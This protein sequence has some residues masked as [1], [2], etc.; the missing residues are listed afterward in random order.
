M[1]VSSLAVQIDEPLYRKNRN[2]VRRPRFSVCFFS[3]PGEALKKDVRRWARVKSYAARLTG[4]KDKGGGDFGSASAW[5]ETRKRKPGFNIRWSEMVHFKVR[6]HDPN[7]IPIDLSGAIIHVAVLDGDS[8][9]IVGIFP[10]NLAHLLTYSRKGSALK[11][12]TRNSVVEPSKPV[13]RLSVMSNFVGNGLRRG[14]ETNEYDRP[15][16]IR[17]SSS[18]ISF[19]S[20][21]LSGG[22]NRSKDSFGSDLSPGKI[23]NSASSGRFGFDDSK[24]LD[25]SV[26]TDIDEHLITSGPSAQMAGTLDSR[27]WHRLSRTLRRSSSL[28]QMSQKFSQSSL[29]AMEVFS[30]NINHSLRKYGIKVGQIQFTVDSFWLSDEAAERRARREN[31]EELSTGYD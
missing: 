1:F 14:K 13:S 3:T 27:R 20:R 21:F 30:M 12:T 31:S 10:L 15:D 17:T 4:A 9:S 24:E 26:Y 11:R 18:G 8:E 25:E 5:P 2:E 19:R 7:G 6:T 22:R 29:D 16:F 23:R 28:R